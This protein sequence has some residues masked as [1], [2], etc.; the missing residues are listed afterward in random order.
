MKKTL[1]FFI[2]ILATAA[3]SFAGET[4]N[5]KKVVVPADEC[6]FRSNEWQVDASVM[7]SSGVY[8]GKGKQSLGGD[9]GI[10][11]FFNR[12]IGIGIDDAVG[13][14]RNAAVTSGT[15]AID[16][17]Q[18]DLLLRYPICAWNLAP[19]AM[20]GGGTSWWGSIAQGNGNVGGGIE[21]R[22]M[23]NV[24]L[25]TDCRWLYGS[26]AS[27]SLTAAFPRVGLRFNF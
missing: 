18:F 4:V 12:Y 27:S 25:F 13:G 10:N 24:G 2:V 23:K 19:Y 21:W 6:R 17:L 9:L 3:A 26:N 14:I 20:V 15:Q 22:F 1:S 5:S 11:Y 16:R 7:G 8:G